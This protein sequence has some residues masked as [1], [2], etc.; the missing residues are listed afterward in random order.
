MVRLCLTTK[1][2][3][4]QIYYSNQIMSS[5]TSCLKSFYTYKVNLKTGQ[6]SFSLHRDDSG[7]IVQQNI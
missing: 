7:F 1:N 6:L 2:T 5:E 3:Y 4:V